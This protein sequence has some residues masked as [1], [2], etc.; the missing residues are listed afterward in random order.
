MN[1][2]VAA[3]LLPCWLWLG[4]FAKAGSLPAEENEKT[5]YNGIERDEFLDPVLGL[6]KKWPWIEELGCA[7]IGIGVSSDGSGLVAVVSPVRQGGADVRIPI[8]NMIPAVSTE[9]PHTGFLLDRRLVS[10][11]PM[12]QDFFIGCRPNSNR[13]IIKTVRISEVA[14]TGRQWI[15]RKDVAEQVESFRSGNSQRFG[16]A[17]NVGVR[18]PRAGTHAGRGTES[19]AQHDNDSHIEGGGSLGVDPSFE[20]LRDL[21]ALFATPRR[22]FA[23]TQPSADGTAS[24]LK[25]TRG[26]E[27]RMVREFSLETVQDGAPGRRCQH[28][29]LPVV[30]EPVGTSWV[31]VRKCQANAEITLTVVGRELRRR[32]PHARGAEPLWAPPRDSRLFYVPFPIFGSGPLVS[33]DSISFRAVAALGEETI[34]LLVLDNSD[35]PLNLMLFEYPINPEK[36]P[37]SAPGGNTVEKPNMGSSL[38]VGHH[39]IKLRTV[40][41]ELVVETGGG[42][43]GVHCEGPIQTRT[44]QIRQN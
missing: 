35:F 32:T 10:D 15:V 43:Y 38:R 27:F 7:T 25:H 41:D 39:S 14:R 22:L 23:V 24:L 37:H 36:S 21:P 18:D 42:I 40:G 34:W 30:S 17:T 6:W 11:E 44:C 12:E 8:E 3:L 5:H 28:W 2:S 19:V 13:L 16:L 33:G 1:L 26:A 9:V 29:T 4:E 31:V 20:Y